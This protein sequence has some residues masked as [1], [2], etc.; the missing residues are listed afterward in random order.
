MKNFRKVSRENLGKTS[1]QTEVVF[2]FYMEEYG[3]RKNT[4]TTEY[5]NQPL[6]RRILK[7]VKKTKLLTDRITLVTTTRTN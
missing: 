7:V 1:K 5:S 4:L 6:N 2:S 3:T